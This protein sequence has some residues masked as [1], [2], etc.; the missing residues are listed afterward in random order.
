MQSEHT[1]IRVIA[2]T[3]STCSVFF[4][5]FYNLNLLL[6]QWGIQFSNKLCNQI[7]C[8]KEYLQVG[9]S[10]L[11]S[12]IPTR[13]SSHE[14]VCIEA[15]QNVV[16]YW[17]SLLI[18]QFKGN[19]LIV[20]QLEVSTHQLLRWSSQEAD[21]VQQSAFTATPLSTFHSYKRMFVLWLLTLSI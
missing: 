17:L 2:I 20:V 14:S 12:W 18:E 10:E 5:C 8:K 15:G 9:Y 16:D 4:F 19:V 3:D 7:L 11:H 21:V 13:L 6:L 1:V